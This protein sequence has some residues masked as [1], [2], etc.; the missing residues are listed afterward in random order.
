[1][2]CVEPITADDAY[3]VLRE[4]LLRMDATAR[5]EGHA[6]PAG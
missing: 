5:A 1:M 6:A 2:S 4:L 3:R